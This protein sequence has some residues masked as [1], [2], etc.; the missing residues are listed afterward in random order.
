MTTYSCM[1]CLVYMP[2]QSAMPKPSTEFLKAFYGDLVCFSDIRLILCNRTY[3][4]EIVSSH[5]KSKTSL[6]LSS[7]EVS[8][9]AARSHF[10]QVRQYWA[11]VRHLCC[12]GITKINQHVQWDL[13]CRPIA[14]WLNGCLHLHVFC[15]PVGVVKIN[16]VKT[17]L[18][19]QA[20]TIL[21]NPDTA[22]FISMLKI[23]TNRQTAFSS[24][25]VCIFCLE[26][27]W[28]TVKDI[29]VPSICLKFLQTWMRYV[30]KIFCVYLSPSHMHCRYKWCYPIILSR[31]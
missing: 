9:W 17:Q 21:I 6:K 3:G 20:S 10:D 4:M 31:S 2:I 25:I 30:Y 22:E 18:S 7:I 28:L 19:F 8:V 15:T 1:P 24:I 12:N 5:E 14:L 13:N 11:D 23:Q 27:Y 16:F 26:V 29:P